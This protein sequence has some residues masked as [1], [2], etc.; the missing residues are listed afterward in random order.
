IPGVQIFTQ[1]MKEAVM[2]AHDSL[3]S[4]RTKQT[5]DENRHRIPSPFEKG[6][7]VYIS[8]KNISFP[9]GRA[10]KLIPK[11]IGPYRVL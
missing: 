10:R 11:Y 7:L 5:R 2:S 6:D 8:T 3:L 9:K 4:Q 1:K